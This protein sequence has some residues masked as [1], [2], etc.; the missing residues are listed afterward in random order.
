MDNLRA[1]ILRPQLESLD[2]LVDAWNERYRTIEAGLRARNDVWLRSRPAKERF[3]GS[4][5]QFR[6]ESL[7][8][9]QVSAFLSTCLER[10]VELKWFGEAV[11]VAY[12]SRYDS[13]Q[14]LEEQRLP[15]TDR[16]LARLFDMRIPLTFS[17]DDCRLIAEIIVDSLDTVRALS[18]SQAG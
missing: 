5:I 18:N 12:T 17:V 6:I 10:G 9:G 11:P 16:V 8:D 3:V 7:E 15:V 14:Y 2:Q 4:S 13:W 1:A